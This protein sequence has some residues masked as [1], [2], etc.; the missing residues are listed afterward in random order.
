MSLS[1]WTPSP[2]LHAQSGA[3]LRLI[4]TGRLSHGPCG[5]ETYSRGLCQSHYSSWARTVRAGNGSWEDLV[6]TG[7]ALPAGPV[8]RPRL[9]E[10]DK[11]EPKERKRREVS[12]CADQQVSGPT[13]EDRNPY[14]PP[15]AP[16]VKPRKLH[17]DAKLARKYD[18]FKGM[19]Y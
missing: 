13:L 17:G 19:G 15:S 2:E 5:R 14:E 10:R 8:G 11:P 16:E 1:N 3:C 6:A 9:P 12:A 7:Q 18:D 4:A